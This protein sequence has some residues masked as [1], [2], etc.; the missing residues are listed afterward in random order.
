MSPEWKS[1]HLK[2]STVFSS[3]EI[4]AELGSERIRAN[5]PICYTSTDS[6][7]QIA[8]HEEVFGLER[9]HRLCTTDRARYRRGWSG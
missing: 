5:R 4:I 7:F 2:A 1:P 8:A 3:T 6:V 9:L